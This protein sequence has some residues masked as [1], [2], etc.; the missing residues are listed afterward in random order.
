M[1]GLCFT[2]SRT[3]A[4]I[5]PQPETTCK[6]KVTFCK[7]GKNKKIRRMARR[8]C[9]NKAGV[10]DQY[11]TCGKSATA[12]ACEFELMFTNTEVHKIVRIS[13]TNR[14]NSKLSNAPET[15][16]RHLHF[17]SANTT[18]SLFLSS[19]NDSTTFLHVLTNMN[20]FEDGLDSIYKYLA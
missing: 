4:Q 5:R 17:C 2:R 10:P 12:E 19:E 3:K 8:F 9:G 1:S 15:K 18:D 20:H 6:I 7:Q 16:H 14:D 11:T 13:K